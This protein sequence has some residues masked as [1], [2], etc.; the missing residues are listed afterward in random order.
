MLLDEYGLVLLEYG[1]NFA[2]AKCCV[3]DEMRSNPKLYKNCP[4]ITAKIDVISANR[5]AEDYVEYL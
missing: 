5:A 1:A 3:I 4:L 2:Y